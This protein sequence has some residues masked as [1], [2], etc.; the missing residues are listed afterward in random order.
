MSE[1]EFTSIDWRLFEENVSELLSEEW[2]L[3]TPGVPGRWNTMTASWGGFGHLWNKDVAFVVVRPSRYTYGFMERETGFTL[4]FLGEGGRK[5][6]EICGARSGRDTDKAKAAGITPRAFPA[7]GV[8]G[9]R[10]GF[11]EARIVVSCRKVFAQ[12]LDP[13]SFVDP[14][15][16][17][18]NYAKGDLHRLYVGAIEGVWKR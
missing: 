5:A 11:E 18:L 16:L 17:P 7:G 6:L 12:N 1:G 13:Y 3:V 2:M 8:D 4:S 15:I 10:V 14:T 9:E